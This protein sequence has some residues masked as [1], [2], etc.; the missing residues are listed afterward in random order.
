M[1][2]QDAQL[3]HSKK[4]QSANVENDKTEVDNH[5]VENRSISELVQLGDYIDGKYT[6]EVNGP[7]N[8]RK[9]NYSVVAQN[10]GSLI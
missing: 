7:S 3:N 4:M 6:E 1:S 10:N 9:A 8:L 2:W 5:V